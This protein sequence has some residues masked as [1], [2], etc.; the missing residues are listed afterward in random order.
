MTHHIGY[1]DAVLGRPFSVPSNCLY[2]AYL[3][4]Y[5]IGYRRVTG[6]AFSVDLA[7]L[8]AS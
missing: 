7:S 8:E 6:R 1:I 2:E 4:H 5:G 3:Y